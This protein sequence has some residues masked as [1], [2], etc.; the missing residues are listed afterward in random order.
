MIRF[1]LYLI[2]MLIFYSNNDI[3]VNTIYLQKKIN[4]G[5]TYIYMIAINSY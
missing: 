3:K 1:L 5:L 2:L 4:D